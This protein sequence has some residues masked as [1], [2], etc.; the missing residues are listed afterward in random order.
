MVAWHHWLDG[1]EFKQALGVGDGQ[2]SLACCS[3]W[4]RKELDT[5]EWLNWTTQQKQD[6]QRLRA[7]RNSFGSLHQGNTQTT[8]QPHGQLQ[9]GG[10]W[11]PPIFLYFLCYLEIIIT[12]SYFSLWQPTPSSLPGKSHGQRSLAGCSPWGCKESGTTERLTL[13]LTTNYR[14]C[15]GG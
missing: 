10:P 6:C 1:H 12:I 2:G 4:G 9:K 8:L 14:I 7:L 3:P 5:I 11:Q 13:T 15:V